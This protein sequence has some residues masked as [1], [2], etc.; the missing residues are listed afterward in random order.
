MQRGRVVLAFVLCAASAAADP[1][2]SIAILDPR[3]AGLTPGEAESVAERVRGVIVATGE[4]AV[5]D[6]AQMN[7]LFT[8][9]AIASSEEC[10]EQ[11][12]LELGAMLQVRYVVAPS[13]RR[14]AE[15]TAVSMRIVDVLQNKPLATVL[16]S[17]RCSGAE[18]TEL[19]GKLIVRALKGEPEAPAALAVKLEPE[20]EL[21][22]P[23][24]GPIGEPAPPR[25]RV[26]R[27]E[28]PAAGPEEPKG[29]ARVAIS[30][31]VMYPATG[32]LG[33]VLEIGL[34]ATA[35]RAYLGYPG[36]SL[37]LRRS[38]DADGSGGYLEGTLGWWYAALDEGLTLGAS[39]GWRWQ[40]DR[41]LF[42]QLGVGLGLVDQE[43]TFVFDIEVGAVAR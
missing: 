5:L 31:G 22:P 25:R 13:A 17:C 26:P 4:F 6:R 15:V 1:R 41:G 3:A 32:G 42:F 34:D 9:L 10:G 38:R 18:L 8:Q 19:A 16:E 30:G 35:V 12:A 2:P 11:C 27:R 36:V 21:A 29:G 24:S 20:P 28:P 33:A 39:G 37:G 7:D 43:A 40:S 14:A 23:P